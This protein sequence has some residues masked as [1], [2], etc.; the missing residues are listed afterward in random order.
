MGISVGQSME[1]AVIRA[2]GQLFDMHRYESHAS[3]PGDH[4][5]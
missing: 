1:S 5:Y 4:L 2:C 3:L